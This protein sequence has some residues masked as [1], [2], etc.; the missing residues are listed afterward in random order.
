MV[1]SPLL[2]ACRECCQFFNLDT[3]DRG[4]RPIAQLFAK[5]VASIADEVEMTLEIR[6]TKLPNALPHVGYSTFRV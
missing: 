4:P 6:E 2:S 1:T 5:A 3:T